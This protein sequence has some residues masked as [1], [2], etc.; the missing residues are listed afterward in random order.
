MNLTPHF[1]L[2]EFIKSATAASKGIDN[3]PPPAAIHN[4]KNLCVGVLEP[5][6]ALVARPVMIRSGYRSRELNAEVG[7]VHDSQHVD[8]E[9]ADIEVP[10]LDNEQLALLIAARLRFDQ[11]I[12]EAY[13]PG[14]PN[15]GWVHVSFNQK[16]RHQVFTAT[17]N[18]QLGK[19]I[20]TPSLPVH[21]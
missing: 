12:L 21:V 13:T 18:R 19:M 7:G 1:K 17:F 11:L 20:Y 3:T 14:Q 9:A 4:L 10:W 5:L 2:E 8:G 16:L 15:S 6:R